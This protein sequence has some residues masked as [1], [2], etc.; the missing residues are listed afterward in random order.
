M[1]KI[2]HNFSKLKMNHKKKLPFNKNKSAI[3]SIR[4]WKKKIYIKVFNL[5]NQKK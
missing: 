4:T 5:T 2:I 1:S 3:S